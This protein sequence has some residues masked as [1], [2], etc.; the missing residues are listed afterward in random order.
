MAGVTKAGPGGEAQG[1]SVFLACSGAGEEFTIGIQ[2]Q[3]EPVTD[4]E[5]RLWVEE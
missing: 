2:T 1:P 3:T 5:H 4:T